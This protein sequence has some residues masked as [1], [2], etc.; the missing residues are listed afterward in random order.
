[1]TT[2]A[3]ILA[4][5]S[6]RRVEILNGLGLKFEVVPS[7]ATE[8]ENL[9]L[10]AVE[11]ARGNATLKARKVAAQHPD[12]IIIGADTVVSMGGK[13]FGK[14]GSLAEATQML[15]ELS[16]REHEVITA[17]CLIDGKGRKMEVVEDHTTV[18]FRPLSTAM[19]ESYLSLVHVM[20]KAGGYAIQEHGEM[21]IESIQG[22][23]SNVMGF[24]VE[25][26]TPVLT[27][28]GL[29]KNL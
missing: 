28:W 1:M 7:G 19:V 24:P 20:D 13:L 22:S 18:R 16:G 9:A 17:V 21:I 4:S 15:R 8:A 26:T 14:P 3:I 11:T 12:S 23:F 5:A 25:K 27:N 6:P 2:T 10:S 29:L